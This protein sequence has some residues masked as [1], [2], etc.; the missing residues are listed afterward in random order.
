MAMLRQLTAALSGVESQF[1][2]SMHLTG[3][4]A[5]AF[6]VGIPAAVGIIAAALLHSALWGLI[7]SMGV[8]VTMFVVA[9]LPIKSKA[10]KDEVAK[11]IEDFVNGTG[12]R[13][14]WD[15]FISVRIADEE[16]EGIRIQ[17][18]RTQSEYPGGPNRWCNDEGLEVL[19]NLARQIRSGK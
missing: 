13:W 7:A 14:D 8:L 5:F 2:M 4:S 6:L 16:L 3:G 19:R 15:D 1:T 10:T 18:L 11:A 12:G 9:A 17:C